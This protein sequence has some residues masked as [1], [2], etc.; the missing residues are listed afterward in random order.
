MHIIAAKAVAFYEAKQPEFA[1]YQQA[2][3]ENA[4]ILAEELMAQGLKLVTGGTDK[5]IVLVDLTPTGISGKIAESA[6]GQVN[7]TVNKNGIPFDPTPPNIT[8]G[9]RLGTPAITTRGFGPGEVRRI[10]KLM[11]KVLGHL[12]DKHIYQEVRDEVAEMN[13]RFPTPGIDQ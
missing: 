5:H 9:I 3:L 11:T 2:V 6:L 4:R 13:H 1:E 12:D 7:I 10:A 8:S